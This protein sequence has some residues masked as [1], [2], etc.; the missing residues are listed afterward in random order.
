MFSTQSRRCRPPSG[1]DTSAVK[2]V[3]VLMPDLIV[4][5]KGESKLHA[6]QTISAT[7]LC[8]VLIEKLHF[9]SLF[10]LSWCFRPANHIKTSSSTPQTPSCAHH[11]LIHHHHLLLPL[12]PPSSITPPSQF[13]PHS[14]LSPLQ[15][16][17]LL[18]SVSY[19][20]TLLLS[21][22]LASSSLL[23]PDHKMC[24]V[25]GGDNK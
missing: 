19:S 23:V 25:V 9:L 16:G 21:F 5:A 12:S 7:R 18:S 15:S 22:L 4:G 6:W 17:R 1:G 10:F 8:S 14:F 13:T 2:A 3:A 11:L 20:P 24:F